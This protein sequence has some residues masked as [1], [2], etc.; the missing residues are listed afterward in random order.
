[1]KWFF[2]GIVIVLFFGPLWVLLTGQVDLS[3]HWQRA[4]RSRANIAPLPKDHP[5][6][7]VQVYAARAYHWRGLFAVHLWIA[8]KPQNATEYTIYQVIGWNL[9]RHQPALSVTRGMPDRRWFGHKPT[10]I[11]QIGGEKAELA[12]PKVEQAVASYPYKNTYRTWPGPNSN[13]FVAYVLRRVPE[14][15][16][17]LPA[18]AIGKDYLEHG[19]LYAQSPSNTGIQFS[20]F[21]LLG[22]HL[23]LAEGL[24]FN[25]LGLSAGVDLLRPAL[26]L[27]SIDRLGVGR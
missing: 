3:T 15:S 13:T 4:D 7:L 18:T 10:I 19:R 22:F 21:G 11:E 20:L 1:M 12:I 9:Y 14:L 2:Y 27:P 16:A 23:G 17:A 26:K 24:E 5:A 6:A 25:V 8:I